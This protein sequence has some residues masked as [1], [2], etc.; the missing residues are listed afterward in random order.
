MISI[1][2]IN[3][4]ITLIFVVWS[5]FHH[6][7]VK[8]FSFNSFSKSLLSK[9]FEIEIENPDKIYANL[10]KDGSFVFK[11][12]KRYGENSIY[13]FFIRKMYNMTYGEMLL[14]I[15][16]ILKKDNLNYAII[17]T[18]NISKY[19]FLSFLSLLIL[20]FPIAILDSADIQN[21][22]LIFLLLLSILL[23][24][25]LVI[26]FFIRIVDNIEAKLLFKYKM[27]INEYSKS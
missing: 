13:Y 22:Y 9:I 8:I 18:D 12:I 11:Q 24:D 10:N 1:I 16:I 4:F 17:I 27:I 19:F 25:F 20:F 21:K 2:Y 14:N 6:L 15:R 23:I 3:F 7:G 26:Y 5:L